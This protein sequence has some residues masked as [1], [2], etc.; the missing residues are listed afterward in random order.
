MF[1]TFINS[2]NAWLNSTN[3]LQVVQSLSGFNYDLIESPPEI[4]QVKKSMLQA[5]IPSSLTRF[6]KEHSYHLDYLVKSLFGFSSYIAESKLRAYIESGI[7]FQLSITEKEQVYSQLQA[8]LTYQ[9]KWSD[10]TWHNMLLDQ[11]ETAFHSIYLALEFSSKWKCARFLADCGYLVPY[12]R[13][14]AKGWQIWSGKANESIDFDSWWQHLLSHS[15]D[16]A[17]AFRQDR[18]LDY[19]FNPQSSI[20]Q[21][22]LCVNGSSCENCP[23]TENCIYFPNSFKVKDQDECLNQIKTGDIKQLPTKELLILLADND[24]FATETQDR[25]IKNYPEISH[26]LFSETTSL[27]DEDLLAKCLAVK[28][29]SERTQEPESPLLKT[30]YSS[31]RDIY[32]HFKK[33]LRKDSQESF[34]AVTLDNKHRIISKRLITLG[35]LNQ[36]L[37]HPREVFASAIQLRAAAIIFVHNHPSGDPTPSN[38]DIAITQR[39]QDVGEIVGIKVLDHVIIGANTFFSFVDENL[40]GS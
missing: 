2:L 30:S 37:V 34:Y 12:S 26:N 19:I 22:P 6:F 39:L 20:L 38:Q 28:E 15:Q 1:S 29:L 8:F 40:L 35:T 13:L 4:L 33:D 9:N 18:L 7:F 27:A 32:N 3:Q 25:L 23:L 14:S 36:S 5:I 10:G 11:P 17:T 24:W 16:K 31:A 21:T